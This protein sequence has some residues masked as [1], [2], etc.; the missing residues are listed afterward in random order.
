MK[1]LFFSFMILLIPA[2]LSAQEE[3]GESSWGFKFKVPS[4][5]V[6]KKTEG[7]MVLGHNS[8]AG[9]IIVFPHMLKNLQQVQQEMQR[10]IKEEG[11]Q[12][13][14]SG[15]L[16]PLSSNAFAGDYQ[17]YTN[18]QQVKARCIGTASPYGG[19][20]FII[21]LTVPEQYGRRLSNPADSIAISMRYL[22]SDVSG[23]AGYFSGTWKHWSKYGEIRVTLAPDGNYNYYDESSYSGNFTE[24]GE[25]TG[26][27]GLAG[28]N[29]EKGVWTVRG[30]R[31]RGT[32]VITYQDGSQDFIE[33]RVHEKNGEIYWNEYYFD[34]KLYTK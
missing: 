21:A 20:A 2:L 24:G 34:G 31:Q 6:Y 15:R 5:W 13:F 14:L 12:L 1:R 10:G 18:N 29:E 19:G 16:M 11:M 27:W 28:Q 9:M 30:T 7:G 23:L 22:K 33:Y 32:L 8:I 4:G 17:G 26:A 25:Q 3:V